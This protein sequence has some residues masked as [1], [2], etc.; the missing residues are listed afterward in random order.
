MNFYYDY[1]KLILFITYDGDTFHKVEMDAKSCS[2]F[3]SL[4][5]EAQLIIGVKDNVS[6]VIK[7]RYGPISNT[8]EK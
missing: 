1:D 5:R 2:A 8:K 6:Y 3:L 4:L 7:F